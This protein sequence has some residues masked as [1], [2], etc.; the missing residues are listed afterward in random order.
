M[1]EEMTR[2]VD[3]TNDATA[4]LRKDRRATAIMSAIG[5]L[6]M[7]VLVVAVLLNATSALA[8]TGTT[9]VTP[10][11]SQ[12]GQLD[13]AA[14]LITQNGTPKYICIKNENTQ[15]LVCTELGGK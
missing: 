12:E 8:S 3:D 15:A 2:L 13:P 5:A 1:T 9:D 4:K 14:Y 6:V 11:Y 7:L 10:V